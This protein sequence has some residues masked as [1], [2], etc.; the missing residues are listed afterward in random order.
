VNF[1]GHH[2]AAPTIASR[3]SDTAVGI[4]HLPLAVWLTI[5]PVAGGLIVAYVTHRLNVSRDRAAIRREDDLRRA[6]E[7]RAATHVRADFS[8]RLVRHRDALRA[9]ASGEIEPLESGHDDIV[10]RAAKADVIDVLGEQYP[11]FMAV[12]QREEAALTALRRAIRANQPVG[13]DLRATL[14]GLE[15]E[16]ERYVALFALPQSPARLKITR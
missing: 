2:H 9:A 13:A 7:Q 10:R 8:F 11:A 15:E 1:F 14:T 4:L 6:S 3:I 16:F 5:I 12:L